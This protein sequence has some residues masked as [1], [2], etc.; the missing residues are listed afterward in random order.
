MQPIFLM[1]EAHSNPVDRS[2]DADADA[3][4]PKPATASFETIQLDPKPPCV[5]KIDSASDN[6]E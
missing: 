3:A 1:L 2:V 5:M 4:A 6:R